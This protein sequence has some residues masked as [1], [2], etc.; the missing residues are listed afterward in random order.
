MKRL[1]I[2]L[3]IAAALISSVVFPFLPVKASQLDSIQVC[4]YGA[5]YAPGDK[6][7][8][9]ATETSDV[10][11]LGGNKYALNAYAGSVNYKDNYDDPNELWKPIDTTI[12]D[13]QITK[14][15][16][17]AVFDYDNKVVTVT[18]KKTG[19]VTTMQLDSLGG[20]SM[21]GIGS[22]VEDG[23]SVTW[24]NVATDT[25]VKVVANNNQIRFE[26][27]L[28]SVNAPTDATFD[29]T[30]TGD[31]S[32]K[33]TSQAQD[34]TRTV[35]LTTNISTPVVSGGK[36]SMQSVPMADLNPNVEDIQINGTLSEDIDTDNVGTIT[37]PLVIDPTL[38]IS[39]AASA[40]DGY[41]DSASS[42][43]LTSAYASVRQFHS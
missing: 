36:R 42:I 23:N 38:N 39:V 22:A 17:T 32:I 24:A 2:N 4:P 33:L 29:I 9:L 14:A 18:D 5:E 13:G 31:S 25:D 8:E 3:L 41:A 37:Y 20:D 35:P 16:Y 6:I 12:V 19:A 30:Q 26:R 11:W 15:P 21:V 27:I 10:T 1:I 34:E 7:A 43:F 40:D 28:K